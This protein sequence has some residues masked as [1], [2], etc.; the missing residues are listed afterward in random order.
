MLK[1]FS[2]AE[3]VCYYGEIG[4]VKLNEPNFS[5]NGRKISRQPVSK[6]LVSSWQRLHEKP[7]S[8]FFENE[9]AKG[10]RQNK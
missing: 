7:R 6:A 3:K 1:L 5:Y 10:L 4:R 9:A 8:R 2:F